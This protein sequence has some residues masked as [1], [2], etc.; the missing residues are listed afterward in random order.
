MK[1]SKLEICVLVLCVV[2]PLLAGCAALSDRFAD[3][4]LKGDFDGVRKCLAE[5]AKANDGLIM[6]VSSR[7]VEVA[8]LLLDGGADPNQGTVAFDIEGP[9][10]AV[11]EKTGSQTPVKVTAEGRGVTTEPS[12]G[13]ITAVDPERTGELVPGGVWFFRYRVKTPTNLR[14]PLHLAIWNDDAAMVRLLLDRGASPSAP[15]VIKDG[16]WG[17]G[18]PFVGSNI[19]LGSLIN[20]GAFSMQNS[21]W[22]RHP[23]EWNYMLFGEGIR[24]PTATARL[25]IRKDPEGNWEGPYRSNFPPI[26][27]EWTTALQWAQGLKRTELLS[28]LKSR[29]SSGP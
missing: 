17:S 9:I 15:Y 8:R 16:N 11:N 14:P 23:M 18:Q 12:W 24:I 28:M 27:A 3:A 6:A 20:N 10:W 22:A 2:G 26:R 4:I 25:S 7:Q 5:G 29:A 21:P 19:I 13:R 1:K